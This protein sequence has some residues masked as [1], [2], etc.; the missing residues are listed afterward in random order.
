LP[1]MNQKTAIRLP[2]KVV[3]YSKTDSRY[4]GQPGRLFSQ[5]GNTDYCCRFSHNGKRGFFDLNT[6]DKAIAQKRAVDRYKYVVLHG[7]EAALKNPDFRT[8]APQT[9]PTELTVGSWIATV[10]SIS[11]VRPLSLRSYEQALRRLAAE[12]ILKIDHSPKEHAKWQ[13]AV[14]AVALTKFTGD[15]L[16]KWTKRRMDS[17]KHDILQA[18]KEKHTINHILRSAKSMFSKK[19]VLEKVAC[20]LL[21]LLPSPLPLSE[22][23]LL[24]E[25][26]SPRFKPSILP[27]KLL[28]LAHAELGAAQTEGESDET[29]SFREQQWIAFILTFCAALRR[30]EGD[31]LQWSQVHLVDSKGPHI[32]LNKTKVFKAKNNAHEGIILLDPEVAKVLTAYKESATGEVFVLRSHKEADV[33]GLK[34]PRCDRTWK[35]LRKWLRSKGEADAKPVHALRKSIGSLMANKFGIHAAQRLLRHTSPTITSKFYTDREASVLPGV[36]ALLEPGLSKA[37]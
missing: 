35:A 6:A 26:G 37:S 13:T 5:H 33:T 32:A 15:V 10:R 36:G 9:S 8:Q 12:A 16:A 3:R 7:W 25:D 11:H 21:A 23:Q 18:E 28:Q 29:F 2:S 27:E 34:R 1:D 20:N 4:W 17:A 30:R 31:L 14:E 24:Q 22:F 19:K